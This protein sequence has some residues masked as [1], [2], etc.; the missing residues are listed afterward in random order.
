MLRRQPYGP[1]VDLWFLGLVVFQMVWPDCPRWSGQYDVDVMEWCD[2]VAQ[3][4]RVALRSPRCTA[5]VRLIAEK[6][7]RPDP[8]ERMPAADLCPLA[9]NVVR[10]FKDPV[11]SPPGQ[12]DDSEG[13]AEGESDGDGA[14][15]G[16]E[17]TR[18]LNQATARPA[19][20]LAP[21]P[22]SNLKRQRSPASNEAS[23][24]AQQ[25]KQPRRLPDIPETVRVWDS[26]WLNNSMAVGSEVAGLGCE[27]PSG[28]NDEPSMSLPTTPRPPA[29]Q[30]VGEGGAQG[31]QAPRRPRG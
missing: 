20:S 18:P 3:A 28:W 9:A 11:A 21:P 12:R 7:L 15:D 14:S 5:L 30:P 6:M 2:A 26:N 17:I 23:P 25:W 31:K 4:A 1:K 10:Q 8:E 19:R 13:E 24:S 27:T 22:S 16:E 29:A